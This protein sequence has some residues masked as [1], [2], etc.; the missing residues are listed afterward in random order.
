MKVL[1]VD[2]DFLIRKWMTILLQQASDSLEILQ[3]EN[4]ADALSQVQEHTDLDLIITDVKMPLMDGLQLCECVKRLYPNICIVIL[5]SYDDF[6][7]VKQALRLGATD[8]ILKAEMSVDDIANALK[9]AE[10]FKIQQAISSSAAGNASF[11]EHSLLLQEFL[12]QPD[13][14][15]AQF[16]H[17][18]DPQLSQKKLSVFLLKLSYPAASS[19]SSVLQ[20][21]HILLQERG[22][23]TVCLAYTRDI[24][25]IFSNDPPADGASADG[26]RLA[27]IPALIEQHAGY[28]VLVWTSL[29]V[30]C[31]TNLQASLAKALEAL[32]FKQYYSLPIVRDEQSHDPDQKQLLPIQLLKN[33]SMFLSYQQFQE[34]CDALT[35]Y[36]SSSHRLFCAPQ[37]IERYFMVAGYRLIAACPAIESNA[38]I[39]NRLDRLLS[40]C[41]HRSTKE[42]FEQASSEFISTFLD[43]AVFNRKKLSSAV[44][45]CLQ[46][47]DA[48]YM[49]KLSL[50]QLAA[51]VFLN[52]T[53]LSK[54]FNKEMGVPFNDFLN[55]QRI[56]HAC[57]YIQT[58]NYSMAQISEMTGFT[59][60]NY[61]TKIF[62]KITGQTPRQYK[63][64]QENASL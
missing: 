39:F 57:E 35:E 63:S 16:L 20:T 37:E 44:L 58:T 1:I 38:L 29:H 59:D 46:Y 55:R 21:I 9:T 42:E 4:G 36:V 30:Q 19:I 10:Q 32:R 31:V 53:Y 54:L 49:E 62:K 23:S 22:I 27:A 40:S 28:Q 5:S 3:A 60:Q 2:D 64:N 47:I 13:A 48:H 24:I 14:D 45:K 6:S 26:N 50:D 52:R 15:T 56:V 8:Y 41:L 18:L 17:S 43:L 11:M 34:A 33:I 12:S 25:M 61:F 51:H 7:Y